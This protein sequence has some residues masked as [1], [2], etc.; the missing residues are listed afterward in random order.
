[1]PANSVRSRCCLALLIALSAAPLAAETAVTGTVFGPAGQPLAGARVELV[2]VL[3][4]FEAGRLRLAGQQDPRPVA[5]GKSDAAGR[6]ALQAPAAGVFKVVV[7]DLGRLPMQYSPLLLVQDEELPPVSLTADAG[8]RAVIQD[9]AG[10]PQARAWVFAASSDE[11]RT[12]GRAVAGWRADFRLGL[13][14][15]DGTVS[16]PRRE[17]E[18]LDVS[19]FPPGGAELQQ[20]DWAGGTMTVKAGEAAVH[21]VRVLSTKGEP[22]G[23]VLVRAG[24]LAWPVGLT[25]GDGR[26]QIPR[27]P[28][29]SG[30]LRLVAADGRQQSVDLPAETADSEV[31]VTLAEPALVAGRITQQETGQ[32]LAGALVSPG[33]DPGAFV[34]AGADGGYRLVAPDPQGFPLR[35]Q[36]LLR[37]PKSLRITPP[38]VR[39]GRIPT[40]ALTRASALRGL[41]VDARGLPLAGAAVLASPERSTEPGAAAALER[42]A[43]DGSGRFELRRLRA[44]TSYEIRTVRPGYLPASTRMPAPSGDA[45]ALKIVLAAA[46]AAH[47]RVR[48]AAGRP[49]SGAEIRLEPALAPGVRRP[50]KEADEASDPFAARTDGEGRFRL[51]GV[52]AERVDLTA[53][54]PG[55]ATGHVRGIRIPPGEG[56]ADLG[57]VILKPGARLPGRVV[58]RRGAPVAG[59]AVHLVES[60]DHLER[61]SARLAAETPDAM[62][63]ADGSFLIEDLPQATPLHLLVRASGHL[64]AGVAGV[65]APVSQP[66][67]VRLEPAAMLRGRVV[68][69]QGAPVGGARVMLTWHPTAPENPDRPA[70][71]PVNRSD[72]AGRDGSFEI[73]DA[74]AGPVRLAVSAPGFVSIEGFETAVPWRDADR[75]LTLTLKRGAMLSGRIATTAGQPVSGARISAQDAADVSDDEGAYTVQGVP[76]GRTEVQVFHPSYKLFRRV[77]EIQPGTNPLD[78]TF[79]AGL[80]VSGRVR[81]GRGAPVAGAQV[82]LLRQARRDWGAYRERTDDDGSFRFAAVARGHYR[83]TAGGES[84]AATEWKQ[85][86]VVEDEPLEGLEVVLERGGTVTGRILGLDAEQLARVAVAAEG[87]DGESFPAMVDA[88]GRYE[89]RHLPPGDYL[90]RAALESGQRQVQAR[91][92]L[93]PGDAEAVRDLQF[94]S[95]LTLSGQVLYQ[96]E[97]LSEARISIRGSRLAMERSVET[98]YQGGFRFEDLEPDTYRLGLSHSRELLVHNDIV[99]LSAD[100]EITI[101]LRP[102]T[103]SGF[104][105]DGKSGRP[106]PHAHLTLRHVE[107]AEFLISDSAGEDGAF[108]VHRVPAGSYLLT[109]RAS[110]YSPAEQDLAVSA[111]QDVSGLEVALAPTRGLELM[112]RLASGRLP[113]RVHLRVVSPTGAVVLTETRPIDP[114]G[115]VDLATLPEGSWILLLSTPGSA[116]AVVPVTVPGELLRVTLPGAGQLHIRVPALVTSDLRATVTLSAAD[117]PFWVVGPGGSLQDR[118]PLVGGKASIEGVPAGRWQ[119]RVES[120]DGRSLTRPITTSGQGEMELMVE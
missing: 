37:L 61:E 92:A 41:V 2:P 16:L 32:P 35:V 95:R 12:Q 73:R 65:R 93:P 58:D 64:P 90:V 49:V 9:A 22:A 44:G 70:G 24:G 63:G 53:R 48:D 26:L 113:D 98:D 74:P 38:H 54:Q 114:S 102:S 112:V 4:N 56:P 27:A 47:G 119:I 101:R 11:G 106:I 36:A 69:E 43:T 39:A 55:Y 76:L 25:D 78:V 1:M 51:D 94:V 87:D 19:V 111:G 85:P 33:L 110:G 60:L 14:G 83:L 8:A 34:L 17:G 117:Q 52:P 84:Y 81:D 108:S 100:R 21:R 15:E 89:I 86:V 71:S 72:I 77:I 20:L 104:V 80:E 75:E 42:S 116:T 40:V 103:V 28:G 62:T 13:T 118:W 96:E 91:V 115:K 46:R 18:R 31:V 45:P 5:Q 88:D 68:D 50:A 79:E 29:Q 109:A 107:G 120:P 82:V 99:E 7:R 67:I 59:A 6:Y 23:G 97:P 30:K 10:R 57:T 3:S 66:L 105:T